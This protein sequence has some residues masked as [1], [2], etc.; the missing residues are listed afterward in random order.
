MFQRKVRVRACG[1]LIEE[2]SLLLLRHEGI[3]PDG[4][5]WSPPGGGVEFGQDSRSTLKREV[6]EETG[7]EVDVGDF[8]FANEHIDHRHHAVELFFDTHRIAG[9]LK[10]GHDPELKTQIL[11]DIRFFNMSKIRELKPTS[12]HSILSR[13]ENLKNLKELRGYYKI[14]NSDI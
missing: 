7:L 10:L 3:G 13:T 5:L 14:D 9:D 8:L 6:K 11:T 4:F 12:V 1:I 2:N